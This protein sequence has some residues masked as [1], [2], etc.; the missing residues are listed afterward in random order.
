LSNT[1]QKASLDFLHDHSTYIY[2]VAFRLTA[3]NERSKDLLQKT[4][5]KA[6]EKI[7]QLNNREAI[8][9]WLKRICINEFLMEER[10]SAVPEYTLSELDLPLEYDRDSLF[11]EDSPSVEENLIADQTVSEIRDGC[12]FTMATHLPIGQRISFSLI[13]MF[14]LS[15]KDVSLVLNTSEGAVKSLLHRGRN[16][17]SRFFAQKCEWV[18]PEGI[19]KCSSWK[20]FVHDRGELEKE[21]SRRR[22]SPL[23][24]KGGESYQ[25]RDEQKEIILKIYQMIP[26]RKPDPSWYEAVIA[27]IS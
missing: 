8:K 5:I 15:F 22:L 18:N 6:W 3:D 23:I 13:D 26:D 10:K 17:I 20:E 2:S 7:S 9:G 12:F 19:C 16:N 11:I 1:S 14:G 4:M 25:I 27:E 24:E 21:V